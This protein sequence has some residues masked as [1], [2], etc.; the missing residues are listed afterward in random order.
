MPT[1]LGDLQQLV[2]LAVTRLGENAYSGA[3][4]DELRTVANRDVAVGTVHVTLVRLEDQGMLTSA[5]AE[6]PNQ[7]AGRPRKCYSLTPLGWEALS[8]ARR[9]FDSMWDGVEPV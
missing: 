6:Q 3:I 4:Q 9:S 1:N 7:G 8:A 2:M 5:R